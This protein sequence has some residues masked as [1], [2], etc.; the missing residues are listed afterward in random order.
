MSIS[1]GAGGL[2]I[3]TCIACGAK[4]PKRD[5]SR[6]VHVDGRVVEDELHVLPGRGAYVCKNGVCRERIRRKRGGILSR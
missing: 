2:P 4:N 1:G 5:M 6:M 3:R